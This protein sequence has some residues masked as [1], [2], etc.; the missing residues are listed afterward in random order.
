M[1]GGVG[2]C[3]C[4]VWCAV[5]GSGLWVGVVCSVRWC[6]WCG[7]CVWVCAVCAVVCGVCVG[8][9]SVC[10]VGGSGLWVCAVCVW[11]SVVCVVCVWCV[12]WEVVGC[13]WVCADSAVVQ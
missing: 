3:V 11:F 6:V 13:G 10:A 5:G 1:V 4:G 9:C 7:V 12:Q 8:V 2:W